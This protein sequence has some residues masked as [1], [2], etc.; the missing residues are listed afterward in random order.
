MRTSA[1]I[2]TVAAVAACLAALLSST[3]LAT[4]PGTNGLLLFQ[5]QARNVTQLFSMAPDGTGLRQ[6]THGPLVSE[7]PAW[8]PDGKTIAFARQYATHAAIL[9]MRADGSGIR[10]LTPTGLQDSPTFTPDGRRIVYA[11]TLKS[12]SLW[13]MDLNGTHQ[14]RLS[15]NP[16]LNGHE[17]PF[18]ENPAVSPDGKQVVFIRRLSE[19]RT[20]LFV[21]GFDGRRL[22]RLTPWSMAAERKVDWSPDG[23]RILFGAKGQLYTIHGDGSGLAKITNGAHDYCSNSYSPDGTQIVLYDKCHSDSESDS[24]LYLMSAAGGAPILVPNGSGARKISWGPAVG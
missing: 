21:I 3:G 11:R 4:P 2:G 7:K 24:N 8:S 10:S 9:L 1:R 16:L 23:S 5:K 22:R 13:V 12:D 6:L 18:D 19:T 20:A 17:F 14:R 15:L